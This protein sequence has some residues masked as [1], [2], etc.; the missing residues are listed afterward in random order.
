MGIH[1]RHL[2]AAF[3]LLAV[4]ACDSPNDPGEPPAPAPILFM[5]L[6]E[7]SSQWD[8][9]SIDADGT[10]L[11]NITASPGEEVYPAWSPDHSMIAYV[12]GRYPAGVFVMNADGTGVRQ[13]SDGFDVN[14]LSWSPDGRSIAMGVSFGGTNTGRDEI[15]VIGVDGGSPRTVT[16]SI[17]ANATSPAWSPDGRSI[18]FGALESDRAS[19]MT[20]NSD[21]TN[22]R[23]LIR[24]QSGGIGT[25]AYSPDGSRIAYAAGVYGR[26]YLYVANADGGKIEQLTFPMGDALITDLG[27]VWSPDASQIAFAREHFPCA[28]ADQCERAVDVYVLDVGSRT[29]RRL[30]DAM[31]ISGSPTW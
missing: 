8:L 16:A 25:P 19:L 28:R 15:F 4:T 27:P 10:G 7:Q 1:L 17:D 11:R 9:Y 2:H 23:T 21:G 5:H 26:N 13:I 24:A 31:G 20:V 14:R 3:L 18:A 6:E 29:V 12:S 30:T 22:P